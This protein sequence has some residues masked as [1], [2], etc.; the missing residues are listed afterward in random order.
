MLQDF[1]TIIAIQDQSERLQ[2]TLAPLKQNINKCLILIFCT[3]LN[4][5]VEHFCT[6]GLAGIVSNL[7]TSVSQEN[8]SGHNNK[9]LQECW[10]C[11]TLVY[12]CYNETLRS[13]ICKRQCGCSFNLSSAD[14]YFLEVGKPAYMNALQVDVL[15]LLLSTLSLLPS[16]QLCWLTGC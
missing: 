6:D 13:Q 14:F 9:I 10:C 12:V 11:S 5:C 15:E 7:N 2:E 1:R 3:T 16:P 8:R 4:V